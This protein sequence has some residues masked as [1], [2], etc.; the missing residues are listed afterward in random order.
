[1]RP[2]DQP[3]ARAALVQSLA[4]ALRLSS[5]A[6]LGSLT[7]AASEAPPQCLSG[8]ASFLAMAILGSNK[9]DA[10]RLWGYLACVPV[11]HGTEGNIGASRSLPSGADVQGI[12]FMDQSQAAAAEPLS[13]LALGLLATVAG[14]ITLAW[15]AFLGWLGL[16]ALR[17]L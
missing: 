15:I 4:F 2:S 14:S 3:L 17:L 6:A 10:I 1:M 11:S 16:K 7:A 12:A 5:I 8:G 9:R 13:R